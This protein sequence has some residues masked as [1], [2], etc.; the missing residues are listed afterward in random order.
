MRRLSP[1]KAHCPLLAL[2]AGDQVEFDEAHL[3]SLSHQGHHKCTLQSGDVYVYI[4][5]F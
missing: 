5:A 3:E 1:S 4:L 2:R